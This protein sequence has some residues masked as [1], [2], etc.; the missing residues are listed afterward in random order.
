MED[1]LMANIPF[2]SVFSGDFLTKISKYS[3]RIQEIIDSYDVVIFMARKAICFYNTMVVNDI[4]VPNPE[5]LVTSSRS[6]DYNVLDSL[7][8]CK[9]RVAVI[10]DV[11]VKG[12]SIKHIARELVGKNISADY[13]AVACEEKFATSFDDKKVN[14]KQTFSYYTKSEIYSFAGLITQYIEASMCPLNIDQPLYDVSLNIEVLQ[15]KL[16]ESGTIDITSGIQRK[17]GITSEVAYFACPA[18]TGQEELIRNVLNNSIL[19]I[20][21][22]SNQ[23]QTIATPF[24]LFPEMPVEILQELFSEFATDI[25]ND[26]IYNENSKI[27]Y[28][29]MLKVLSYYLS[30]QF[31]GDFVK[32]ANLSEAQPLNSNDMI[33]FCK[34]TSGNDRLFLGIPDTFSKDVFEVILPIDI[35]Y[36]KFTFTQAVADFYKTISNIDLDNQCYE[37]ENGDKISKRSNDEEDG[38]NGIVISLDDICDNITI[39]TKENLKY[40]ASTLV[41]IFIDRGVIVPSIVHKDNKIIRAYKMGEY[42]KLT[43]EHIKVF[44][45]M[46]KKYQDVLNRELDKTEFEKLCVLCFCIAQKEK[47]FPEQVDFEKDCYGIGYSLYGPRVS[48]GEVAYRVDSDS[49]LITNFRKPENQYVKKQHGKYYLPYQIDPDDE[50]LK[51]FCITLAADFAAI[52]R[53][54]EDYPYNKEKSLNEN[55]LT[56]NQYLTLAAIGMSRKNQILSLCAEIYQLTRLP[57][58]ILNPALQEYEINQCKLIFSGIDSGL[59]KYHCYFENVLEKT[60]QKMLARDPNAIRIYSRLPSISDKNPKFSVFLNIIGSLLFRSAF[61]L[62]GTLISIPHFST[63]NKDTNSGGE[64]VQLP[65]TKNKFTKSR[66]NLFRNSYWRYFIEERKAIETEISEYIN[67]KDYQE[68]FKDR[69]TDYKSEAQFYLDL[70]DLYL[71]TDNPNFGIHKNILVLYSDTGELPKEIE[72][73]NEIMFSGISKESYCMVYILPE[74]TDKTIIARVLHHT[75][76]KN[77]V[78]YIIFNAQ[79]DYEGVVQI[80]SK[81]KGS[82][83][84]KNIN[85]ILTSIKGAQIPP[86]KELSF[87]TNREQRD[88]NPLDRGDYRLIKASTV[89]RKFANH[90]YF[91]TKYSIIES[92]STSGEKTMVEKIIIKNSENIQVITDPTAP[93]IQR[94][95]TSEYNLADDEFCKRLVEELILLENKLGE[96]SCPDH[97]VLQGAVNEAKLAINQKDESKI[98]IALK[99]I[100]S[101]GKDFLVNVSAGVLVQYMIHFRYLPV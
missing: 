43:A 60:G 53:Y 100:A 37:D 44:T 33:Q 30:E 25:I 75:F 10:D 26:F 83:F 46:L 90:T 8:L 9:K 80:E 68:W 73:I 48:Q 38:L 59:W 31:F 32:Y 54:F 98:K 39:G 55:V 58:S 20:R 14:L 19:K 3:Q 27:K 76:N 82:A 64:T 96:V 69:L 13:Y 71:E 28:E 91:E 40:Y 77:S 94:N 93:V 42:S 79:A 4:V 65:E 57:D 74:E 52:A 72:G 101:V 86:I 21:F 67:T 87:F 84:K 56:R 12:E 99:K 15:K 23:K 63:P 1:L 11:V 50:I 6:I 61:F 17:Y 81:V 2:S 7:H 51:M 18:Y 36:N 35:D 78:R 24:V 85:E 89:E 97:A 66:K 92:I 41:D 62:N 45:S 70:C 95:I 16:R 29:N 22:M 34:K 88:D 47:V 5:C 49:V